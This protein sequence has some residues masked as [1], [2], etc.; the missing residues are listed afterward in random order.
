MNKVFKIFLIW[1]LIIPL[2]IANG[3]FRDFVLVPAIGRYALPLSGV[4]LSCLILLVAFLCLP[5]LYIR[6]TRQA[7][8][9]GVCWVILTVSFEFIFGL[10][11]GASL[12]SL[13]Q[14][15]DVSTGNLWLLVVLTTGFAPFLAAKANKVI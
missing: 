5:Y 12:S 4:S 15:Y 9:T 7:V 14:A 2:A 13:L 10:S 11:N 3:M 8:F 6:S 1:A